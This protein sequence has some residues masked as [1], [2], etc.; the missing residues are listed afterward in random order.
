MDEWHKA[1]VLC[2]RKLGIVEML[3]SQAD[4]DAVQTMDI[5]KQPC[6]VCFQQEDGIHIKL[7]TQAEAKELAA[8]GSIPQ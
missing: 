1:L 7:T 3:I 6:A 2:F 8:I 5:D 4:M